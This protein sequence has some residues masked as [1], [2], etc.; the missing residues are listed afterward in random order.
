[1]LIIITRAYRRVLQGSAAGFKESHLYTC[2]H[3][4]HAAYMHTILLYD[5]VRVLHVLI[6]IETARVS[7]YVYYLRSGI[8]N[9]KVYIPLDEATV[10]YTCEMYT[11]ARPENRIVYY[12]HFRL[13]DDHYSS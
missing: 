8:H 2:A 7:M 10:F 12:I 5:V 3:I 9:T 6:I 11:R 4:Q 1:M 13:L